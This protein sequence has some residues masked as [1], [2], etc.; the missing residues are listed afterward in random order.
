MIMTHNRGRII[1]II[2]CE[3][4]GSSPYT[5]EHAK[6]A[7]ESF[8]MVYQKI[9]ALLLAQDGVD[10]STAVDVG[11]VITLFNQMIE[12]TMNAVVH[13]ANKT[14]PFVGGKSLF[15]STGAA[16]KLVTLSPGHTYGLE[17][18]NNRHLHADVAK[19]LVDIFTEWMPTKVQG[20]GIVR[21]GR[22]AYWVAA[23]RTLRNITI[24]HSLQYVL[25]GMAMFGDVCVLVPGNPVD[26]A[27]G[28]HRPGG[29][30]LPVGWMSPG[31]SDEF[32]DAMS[33]EQ[34]TFSRMHVATFK[35]H[36]AVV[37][38]RMHMQLSGVYDKLINVY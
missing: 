38:D 17:F 16:L 15:A 11:I 2:H 8:D 10:A 23:M 5:A 9:K 18:H 4:R 27:G 14:A 30:R 31:D 1:H 28:M 25:G 3:R 7:R 36:V 12:Y 6:M 21:Y 37:V 34:G 26:V 13:A 24:H 22:M 19:L 32:F 35:A 29:F 33:C 20:T